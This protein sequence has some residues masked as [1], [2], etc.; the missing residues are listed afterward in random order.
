MPDPR[1]PRRLRKAAAPP[2][3]AALGVVKVDA[4]FTDEYPD[5]D[6]QCAEVHAT[7][8]RAG[9]AINAGVERAALASFGVP[10]SVLT[11]LAVIEGA[12][13]ALTPSQ[14]SERTL[15]SSATMTST[16]DSLEYLGW[17]RR[18]P[19]PADRRS[20]LL[21]ITPEGQAVADR[22]L[23]GMR[24]LEK[25]VLSELTS[26]ELAILLELLDK[27]LRGAAKTA[28][29]EPIPLDGRRNRLPRT[30]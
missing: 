21:E 24:T 14:V 2:S 5:G 26:A 1:R 22:F 16:L 25:S 13:T 12:D 15:T 19:N 10:Q 9:M 6:P 30:R 27:V 11:S 3:P 28:E 23:P 20:V 4:D 7:L 18:V 29:A 17:A 8:M